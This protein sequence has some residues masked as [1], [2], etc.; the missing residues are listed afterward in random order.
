MKKAT[1][2]MVAVALVNLPFMCNAQTENPRGVYKMTTLTGKMG[3]IKAP[4][5]QYKICTDE[6]TL[7][8]SIQN[9]RF[10]F[11]NTDNKVFDYTGSEP[12]DENDKSTLIYDSNAEHFTEKWWS[13][14][15]GHMYFPE[16]DWC[17]EKYQSGLYSPVGQIVFDALMNA[18]AADKSNPLVGTWR[19]I[20]YVDEL[21]HAQKDIKD[22]HD[23]YERSRYY[24]TFIV[25][26]PSQELLACFRAIFGCFTQLF[27]R[28]FLIKKFISFMALFY[29]FFNIG[30][31]LIRTFLGIFFRIVF[32]RE[33]FT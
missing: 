21:N 19:L 4:F 20:G 12:K 11:S 2:W 33:A 14:T 8:V 10:Q 24:N 32:Y 9:N 25:V 13:D 27:V 16:N 7:M 5:D 31:Q 17:I 6:G 26:T 28:C 18:P 30:S 23:N 1:R 15:R 29:K 3:E 22:L